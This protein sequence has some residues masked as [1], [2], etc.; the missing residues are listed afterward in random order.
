MTI[1]V[2]H[3][4]TFGWIKDALEGSMD[5]VMS[6]VVQ[7]EREDDYSLLESAPK[8]LHQI[9]GSLL[10][11]ELEAAG[12]LAQD[13]ETLCNNI[14][15]AET[16]GEKALSLKAFRRGMAALQ[17]YVDAIAR[18]R[19]VSPLVLVDQINNVRGLIGGDLITSF[20]LFEPP[21]DLLDVGEAG[22]DGKPIPADLRVRLVT[23]LR[24]KYRRALLRWL[25]GKVKSS[26]SK[27]YL[28]KIS[29]LLHHLGKVSSLDVSRQLWWV[30][31]GFVDAVGSGELDSEKEI[32]SQF[33]RLDE[34]I[35][36]L[37]EESAVNIATDPP[38][39]LLRKMLFYIG[40]VGEVSSSN[41]DK[42]SGALE[43]GKWF[44]GMDADYK[45]V[46]ETSSK[47]EK[48][49]ND[50]GSNDFDDVEILVSESFAGYEGDAKDKILK[51]FGSK[52]GKLSSLAEQHDV[53]P[54]K[55]LVDHVVNAVHAVDKSEESI[56]K[57][58]A[59]IK[60]ASALLFLRDIVT[61]PTSVDVTWNHSVDSH[62][63]ELLALIGQ[64]DASHDRVQQVAK[65]AQVEYQHAR[66]AIVSQIRDTLSSVETSINMLRDSLA[67]EQSLLEA[68]DIAHAQLKQISASLGMV[69]ADVA[70][71]LTTTVSKVMQ[72]LPTDGKSAGDELEQTYEHLA[73]AIAALDVAAENISQREGK[74]PSALLETA[75]EK[76]SQIDLG[77]SE[78]LSAKVKT[79]GAEI[80][81]AGS[82]AVESD[83]VESD[84]D[85]KTPLIEKRSKLIA[86]LEQAR[87]RLDI[88]DISSSS[89]MI[90]AF[91]ALVGEDNS[92]LDNHHAIVQLAQIGH[93]IASQSASGDIALSA[94]KE[95]FLGLLVRQLRE[96]NDS[97]SAEEID[98]EGWEER[99]AALLTNEASANEVEVDEVDV[100]SSV[101]AVPLVK[102]KISGADISNDI[103]ADAEGGSAVDV[104]DSDLKEIFV[105]EYSNH[106][107]LLDNN[108]NQLSFGSD[109]KSSLKK[110]VN[111]VEDCIHT[112][113]GNCRNLGFD[114]AASCAE[115]NLKLLEKISENGGAVNA[116]IAKM[117]D[118]SLSLLKESRDQIKLS[119]KYD[120]DLKK[121]FGEQTESSRLVAIAE[122]VV[123]DQFSSDAEEATQELG[124]VD[125]L[126]TSEP[127]T[128]QPKNIDP[129]SSSAIAETA[130]VLSSPQQTSQPVP[131]IEETHVSQESDSSF[132]D[133]SSEIEDD[134]DEEIREIFLEESETVLGRIN[135]LLMEWRDEGANSTALGGIRREFHTLKGSAAAT[136]YTGVS[137][138]SHSIESMLDDIKPDQDVSGTGL[139]ELLEEMHD[140]LAADLGFVPTDKKGHI[141]ELRHKVARH[142]GE[143]D[144][145]DKQE[146][147]NSAT[148]IDVPAEVDAI[149]QEEAKETEAES[150]PIPETLK[151]QSQDVSAQE[152]SVG[153]VQ[154]DS[155]PTEVFEGQ[156][157]DVGV[158][159]EAS[160]E[161]ET[162]PAARCKFC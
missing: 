77:E 23:Q 140:G 101:T 21:L 149:A 27:A 40:S 24:K 1:P 5:A 63:E 112:L 138:L 42:I 15:L 114:E 118:R 135:G 107:A 145:S 91:A 123:Q 86:D 111:E 113:A 58:A 6:Q 92:E 41:I 115:S 75:A 95:D 18:Q 53:L 72:K 50:F 64:T 68:A 71:D 51:E 62:Q 61:N 67:P 25:N 102:P 132:E 34:E 157:Q 158:Q 126:E 49:K 4:Q 159:E 128:D 11:V 147:S 37:E 29:S 55:S 9:H 19:P 100:S 44:G 104:L 33:A 155:A 54:V 45:V 57:T 143:D 74:Q 89:P 76:L 47:L 90:N 109:S 131:D 161:V 122:P 127:E 154:T 110:T 36:R 2:P 81:A 160:E 150:T 20:D 39:H 82:D 46:V 17:G 141:A 73:F 148:Q 96:L 32:K 3:P 26:E 97:E 60:I 98:I 85:K 7:V 153:E 10:M 8:N 65:I 106:L 31:S 12:M 116:E 125:Q 87:Q 156:P 108:F 146:D 136:G 142:L 56:R 69:D 84:V 16:S 133:E 52:L 129:V 139:L 83:I 103:D 99:Y 130:T 137:R 66:S 120:E 151:E 59:D 13:L 48:I 144:G 94:D 119:G 78:L 38:D 134:I 30:A 124:Q 14:S 28:E 80:D 105:E 88:A 152:E 79:D 70:A 162:E 121:Q 22:Y 35:S 43:L 93:D 117:L